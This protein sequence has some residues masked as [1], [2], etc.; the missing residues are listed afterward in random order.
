MA[1]VEEKRTNDEHG[2]GGWEYKVKDP[3]S[4]LTIKDKEGKPC[5]FVQK[6]LKRIESEDGKKGAS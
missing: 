5:W 2:S 6:V 3:D 1:I 4:G